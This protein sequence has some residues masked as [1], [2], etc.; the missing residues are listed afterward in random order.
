M[1]E[2]NINYGTATYGLVCRMAIEICVDTCNSKCFSQL[3]VSQGCPSSPCRP[4]KGEVS[5]Y[6]LNS[7]TMASRMSSEFPAETAISHET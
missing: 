3:A 2:H 6:E 4:H 7:A 1:M 5:A